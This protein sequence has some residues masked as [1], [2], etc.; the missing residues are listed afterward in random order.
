M[1]LREKV[2]IRRNLK[3][4]VKE[5]IEFR[6]KKGLSEKVS[7][8]DLEVLFVEAKKMAR[9][10]AIRE[11]AR[12]ARAVREAEEDEVMDEEMPS[13]EGDEMEAEAPAEDNDDSVKDMINNVAAEVNRIKDA[14]GMTVDIEEPAEEEEEA[15]VEDEEAPAEEEMMEESV[16]RSSRNRLARREAVMKHA[17][18][19]DSKLEGFGFNK[20]DGYKNAAAD[21]VGDIRKNKPLTRP[22]D[23]EL[24][25]GSSKD[26]IRWGKDS[27]F[28]KA[29]AGK[30]DG[31]D[32]IQNYID[33][34]KGKRQV[35]SIL[36]SF[37]K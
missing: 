11:A 17:A 20:K 26:K 33:S 28:V 23:K 31:N 37:K 22:S 9:R 8:R 3:K 4:L 12:R 2:A 10:E 36:N 19:I 14:M 35:E 29:K 13:E 30:F 7:E 15:P 24:A 34:I 5:Y 27:K 6:V 18:D 16:L 25:A 1:E 21:K 32:E